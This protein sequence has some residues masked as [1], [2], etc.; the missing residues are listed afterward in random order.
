MIPKVASNTTL[1]SPEGL[2]VPIAVTPRG[3]MMYDN[4]LNIPYTKK[5]V[6]GDKI[7]LVKFD[8][9]NVLYS[10]ILDTGYGN[11]DMEIVSELIDTYMGLCKDFLNVT[12]VMAASI[13]NGFYTPTMLTLF[14]D[15]I[16]NYNY[17]YKPLATYPQTVEDYEYV[18][19]HRQKPM[20]VKPL[21]CDNTGF[22]LNYLIQG[23]INN[24]GYSTRESGIQQLATIL[25]C[26][27]GG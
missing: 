1:M 26:V 8:N 14:E 23:N 21:Q 4:N 5:E 27:F 22:I 15:I 18:L 25:Y 10:K 7:S 19:T 17:D 16:S 11:I 6:I 20:R 2:N 24:D 9:V 12:G 13:N 3:Y